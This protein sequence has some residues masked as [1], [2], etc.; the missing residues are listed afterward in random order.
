MYFD[1]LITTE[2]FYKMIYNHLHS[3]FMSQDGYVNMIRD[4]ILADCS[5]YEHFEHVG[6]KRTRTKRSAWNVNNPEEL[7]RTPWGMMLQD[8]RLM[9][10]DSWQAASFGEGLEFRSLS[11]SFW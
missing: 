6:S 1:S 2:A 7:W 3:D 8:E 11:F 10:P 9:D 4:F 5:I